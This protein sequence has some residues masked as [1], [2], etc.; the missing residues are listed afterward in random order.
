ML[1]EYSFYKKILSKIHRRILS[2]N[3]SIVLD[4]V[5]LIFKKVF[6]ILK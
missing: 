6:L 2:C 3:L 4:N 5:K 1:N